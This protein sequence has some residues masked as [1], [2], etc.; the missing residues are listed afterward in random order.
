MDYISTF[1]CPV[2]IV[3][4]GG[5]EFREQ[6]MTDLI[7][8]LGA[9]GVKIIPYNPTGNAHVERPWRTLK[10]MMRAYISNK[11]DNWDILLPLFQFAMNTA[12]NESTGF[13]PCY[14]QFGRQV[15]TPLEVQ[16]ESINQVGKKASAYIKE[17]RENM[18]WVFDLAGE[19]VKDSQ[20]RA[21]DRTQSKTKER[22]TIGVGDVVVVRK[23]AKV[24]GLNKKL[25]PKY[26]TKVYMV[27][28]RPNKFFVKLRNVATKAPLPGLV[29]V[30]RVKRYYDRGAT[31]VVGGEAEVA[32][33]TGSRSR[34]GRKEFLVEWEGYDR[35]S[36]KWISEEEL[37]APQLV[38]EFRRA[39]LEGMMENR[40][41]V[42]SAQI[43]SEE[44]EELIGGL[45]EEEG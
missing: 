33:V 18:K 8:I 36:D 35:R 25:L 30:G 10:E 7:K 15:V 34:G 44:D 17:V 1:G 4:D 6:V 2:R 39:R 3:T 5:S 42:V 43:S 29:K 37:N 26:G 20:R 16:W 19:K 21:H 11:Q 13:T 38:Q 45:W 24:K 27:T 41:G 14:L 28:E 31:M 23:E 40:D 12:Y 9:K 32:K 22:E